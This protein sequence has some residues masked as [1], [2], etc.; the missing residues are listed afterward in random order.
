MAQNIS[1]VPKLL[2]W[3]AQRTSTRV[4]EL[5]DLVGLDPAQYRDRYPRELS[6]G[7]Q[8]RV[9]VARGLAADPPVILMDE[10]FGAVDPI[11][12]QR[13][14]D[15]LLSIQRELRKTIVCV[16]H[17]IDEAIKLGDRIVILREGAEIAQYDTPENIL[18]APGRRLR[19]RLRGLRLDAQAALPGPGLGDRARASGRPHGG[20]ATQPRRSPAPSAP[21][22]TRSSC[23]TTAD[24]PWAGR[25]CASCAAQTVPA[26]DHEQLHTLDSRATLND[27]LDTMLTSS[28][29]GAVVTGDRD[30]FLGVI[31]LRRVTDHMRVLRSRGR[32]DGRRGPV[33]EATSTR[34]ADAAATDGPSTEGDPADRRR[35]GAGRPAGCAACHA[36]PC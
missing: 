36:R 15:E 32:R 29:G 19:Q 31:G 16:T 1:I 35:P 34:R 27:A 30:Q 12:R 7:Q 13:L 17:D 24:A 5:L 11:T 14:Q 25:G 21:G 3:D 6:G 22:T 20:R 4:D 33:T 8:Q 2:G 23:S 18:A 28:H 26:Y 10:P 9:G